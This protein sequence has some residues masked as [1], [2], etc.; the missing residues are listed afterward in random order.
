VRPQWLFLSAWVMGCGGAQDVPPAPPP[1]PI[2]VDVPEWVYRIPRKDGQICATGAV[3]P[4]F[5]RQDGRTNAAET[6]R[7]ELARTVQV[8]VTAVMYDEQTKD[9]SYVDQAIVTEVIGSI[10]EAVISGAEVVSYWFDDHGAVSKRGMTYA[11]ACM[12]TD[13]S[14][15]E[16]AEKLKTAFPEKENEQKIEEVKERARL[17][18]EELEKLEEKEGNIAAP[19]APPPPLVD[20]P[21][22][23]TAVPTSQ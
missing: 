1:P 15:A 20:A 5:Y 22:Q 7:G 21:G 19:V 10:S 6:A 13:Q 17:A 14:V 2:H 18:F 9:G 4:T 23:P 12:R 11:L 16:L 8:Q 3:D